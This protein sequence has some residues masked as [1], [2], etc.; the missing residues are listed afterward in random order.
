[1]AKVGFISFSTFIEPYVCQGR[2]KGRPYVSTISLNFNLRQIPP[3]Y[4]PMNISAFHKNGCDSD[5]EEE[6]PVN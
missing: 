5:E 1:M 2:I 4:D 6:K 3:K